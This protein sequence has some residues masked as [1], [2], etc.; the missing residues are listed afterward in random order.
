VPRESERTII[1]KK[2]SE[3]FTAYLKVGV[4]QK[5]FKPKQCFL[6][7]FLNCLFIFIGITLLIEDKENLSFIN[8]WYYFF[9]FLN[10]LVNIFVTIRMF[11]KKILK[12]LEVKVCIVSLTYTLFFSSGL[13]FLIGLYS[14]NDR[15]ISFA[16]IAI[17]LFINLSFLTMMVIKIKKGSYILAIKNEGK[18]INAKVYSISLSLSLI[19]GIPINLYV[20]PLLDYNIILKY[21]T[22]LFIPFTLLTMLIILGVKI[23]FW[24]KNPEFFGFEK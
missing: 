15:K 13:S 14:L 9:S 20:W 3:E 17:Y 6:F 5:E 22:L 21:T 7:L 8:N 24:M 12:V 16:F 23:F 4:S 18:P 11:R 19:V 2:Y 10:I 1:M